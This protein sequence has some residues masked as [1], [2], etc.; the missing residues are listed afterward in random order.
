MPWATCYPT[1][2]PPTHLALVDII[3]TE[4]SLEA[5]QTDAR[6]ISNAVNTGS[7][8]LTVNP[9]AVVQVDLTACAIETKGAG[10]L[11]SGNL[12]GGQ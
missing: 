9:K 2:L 7:S 11:V 3:C 8:I 4:F 1:Y 12:D 5:S 10:A 6:A